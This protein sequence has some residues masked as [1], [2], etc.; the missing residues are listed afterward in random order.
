MSLLL[1]RA[2]V[3]TATTGTGTVTLGAAVSPFQTWAAAQAGTPS[4]R[5]Y[6]YLIEDGTAWEIGEGVYNEGANT[7]TRN[8][9]AS[10]TGALLNLSGSATVACVAK[11]QDSVQVIEKVSLSGV[12]TYTFSDIPQDFTSLQLEIFGRITTAVIAENPVIRVNGLSTAIYDTQRSYS[13][14]TANTADQALAA[15]SWGAV[16]G[17]L[18]GASVTDTPVP[19][20][21]IMDILGYSQTTFYK[22]MAFRARQPNNATSGNGFQLVGNG[23]ARLTAAITSISVSNTGN[24]VAG[25]YMVLRGIP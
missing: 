18:P 16:I 14:S 4:T 10:S 15:T 7:L 19:G 12:N 3:Q 8:L 2:K 6:S 11:A 13:Q 21:I 23:I 17:A 5:R 22:S 24:Y 1:N 9:V 25:T 20:H